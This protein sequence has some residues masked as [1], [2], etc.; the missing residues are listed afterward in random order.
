MINFKDSQGRQ[1]ILS[2][3]IRIFKSPFRRKTIEIPCISIKTADGW[4]K[5]DIQDL[6]PTNENIVA[7]E[8]NVGDVFLTHM[9]I[10]GKDTYFWE[11]VKEM[12]QDS[13]VLSFMTLEENQIQAVFSEDR[14]KDFLDS[15]QDLY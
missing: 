5:F 11:V 1:L 2:P 3:T 8:S 12:P 4:A 7:T 9:K 10:V 13:W 6:V 15:I 14:F